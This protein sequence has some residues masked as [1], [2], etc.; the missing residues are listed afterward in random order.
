MVALTDEMK[1][2]LS[3]A[4]TQTNKAYL[5]V[6]RGRE[7]DSPDKQSS[8]GDATAKGASTGK[9]LGSDMFC[10]LPILRFLQLL[11]ENHNAELQV[12]NSSLL[13]TCFSL[14]IVSNADFV[15][16]QPLLCI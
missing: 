7:V 14:W 5:A 11:C 4:A 3:E 6:R 15:L 10:M 16:H 1:E 9:L 13:N 12:L 8:F 2:Q